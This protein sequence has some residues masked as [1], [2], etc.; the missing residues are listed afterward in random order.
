MIRNTTLPI[1][2]VACCAQ[3]QTTHQLAAIDFEFLPPVIDAVEGDSLRISFSPTT[4]TFTQVSEETW[5]TNGTEP[6]GNYN[7]GPGVSQ[8]TIPLDAT[9]TIHYI[10]LPH[11]AMGMKGIVNV[12][13]ATDIEDGPDA[14]TLALY[15]NPAN[16]QVWIDL[17]VGADRTVFF[18]DATGREVGRQQVPNDLPLWIGDLPPGVYVVR[19]LDRMHQVLLVQR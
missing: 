10:C 1:L 6:E 12:M 5:N 4:H 14:R 18:L 17:P 3:A 11:A 19:T 16:E 9:G 7:I 8:I 15:P 2:F 13:L